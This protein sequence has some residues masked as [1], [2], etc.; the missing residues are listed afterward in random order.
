MFLTNTKEAL[1]TTSIL[2]ALMTSVLTQSEN[3]CLNFEFDFGT[4]LI[5]HPAKAAKGGEDSLVANRYM[6]CV[7]DGV[8]SWASE[9]IDA[10]LYSRKLTSNV[11]NF[12]LED[13]AKYTAHPKSLTTKATLRNEE[14]GSSTIVLF[15]IDP[16]TGVVNASQIGDSCYMILRSDPKTG[17][18]AIYQRSDEQQHGFNFPYQVGTDGDSPSTALEFSHRVRHGDIVI[19]ASDGMFDNLY[20]NTTLEEVE[21]LKTSPPVIIA[22]RLAQ[23]AFKLSL[24]RKYLSPFAASAKKSKVSFMGGKSD[25]IAVVVAFV[26]KPKSGDGADSSIVTESKPVPVIGAKAS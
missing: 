17:K 2:F 5:P 18:L 15:V 1:L 8:G 14:I 11:A 4:D 25:D 20:D 16:K 3:D 26:V 7:A 13:R 9:G 12:Y 21:N 24:N 6:L 23:L 19:V 22:R 10:A